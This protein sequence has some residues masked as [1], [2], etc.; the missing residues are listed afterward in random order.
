VPPSL[1]TGS[2]R[3]VAAPE[4]VLCKLGKIGWQASEIG[5]AVEWG[6]L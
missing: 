2:P 6:E 1:G 3:N 5:S 4:N